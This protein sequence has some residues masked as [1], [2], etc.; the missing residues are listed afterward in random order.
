MI[1]DLIKL[2]T[3]LDRKG[4]HKEASF[5]DAIIKKADDEFGREF[6]SLYDNFEGHFE[7]LNNMLPKMSEESKELGLLYLDVMRMGRAYHRLK[8]RQTPMADTM[9]EVEMQQMSISDLPE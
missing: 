2:A 6:Q 1:N 3:H 8:K 5:V 9:P 4:F 7:R